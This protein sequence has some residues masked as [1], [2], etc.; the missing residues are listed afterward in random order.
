MTEIPPVSFVDLSKARVAEQLEV[1]QAIEESGECPFCP[2][3]LERLSKVEVLRKGALWILGR[4]HWPYKNTTDHLLAI[5]TYHAESIADL[6]PGAFDE[7]QDH[8]VWAERELEIKSGG[9]CMRFG[10]ITQNGATVNHVHAHIIVPRPH[11]ADEEV[12]KKVR[13]KIW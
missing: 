1:M 8:A 3:N 13:F 2:E 12:D 7:L 11:T 5:A 6:R 9:L 4:N 10:D